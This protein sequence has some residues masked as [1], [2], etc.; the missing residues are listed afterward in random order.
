MRT[1]PF[2]DVE[3]LD[4]HAHFFSHRFFDA[5]AAQSPAIKDT[6]DRVAR[7]GDATGW[8]MPPEDPAALGGAW[9]EELDRH[10]VA[11]A[12]LM[13]SVPTDEASIAA[14]VAAHPERIAGAFMLDPTRD[15]RLDRAAEAFDEQG[16]RVACLFPAMHRFSVAESE[17]VRAVVALSEARPGTAVFVHF[18]ALSVGVRKKLGLESRFDLRF[19]NPVDLHPIAAAFPRARFVVPHFGA[20]MLREALMVADLCPNVYLDTSSSNKWMAYHAPRLELAE[21]FRRALDVVGH[22]RLLFGTD[23]S[24]FPRGWQAA[25]FA[26]QAAALERAGATDEQARAIFGGNL[27]RLLTPA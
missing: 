13:A 26:A 5:L 14:A 10:G 12:L 9:V 11:A 7:V 1:T 18:G 24:F 8:T 22:E 23:S 6:P 16:L 21:V 3:V 27:R 2:G 19:S 25:V 17:G 4:A 20:G 15:D